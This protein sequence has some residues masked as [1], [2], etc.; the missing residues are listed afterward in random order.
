MNHSAGFEGCW[1]W[2]EVC[3]LNVENKQLFLFWYKM[4]SFGL[5]FHGQA[6]L[7][8]IVLHPA[9]ILCVDALLIS[10]SC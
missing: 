9:L 1:D 7:N 8:A 3:L 10:V 5:G 6:E 2:A 4:E